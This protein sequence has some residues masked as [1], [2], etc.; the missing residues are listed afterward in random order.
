M[1]ILE[2]NKCSYHILLTQTNNAQC[3]SPDTSST[4]SYLPYLLHTG[5]TGS[6]PEGLMHPG[7]SSVQIEDQT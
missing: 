6:L 2:A 5:S 3:L 1:A 4:T 7:D